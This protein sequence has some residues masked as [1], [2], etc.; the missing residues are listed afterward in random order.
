M[1]ED[2]TYTVDFS[3]LVGSKP[4]RVVS[5][6]PSVTESLFD[7]QLQERIIAVTDYCEHPAEGVARLPRVGGTKNPNI[8]QIVALN[9]DLV[10]MNAEENRREDAQ[11][12]SEA[13]VR[14]YAATPHT[15]AEAINELWNLVAIFDVT[16]MVPRIQ[17]IDRVFDMVSQAAA[18]GRR[19]RT[20]VPIW[21]APWMT[22]NAETYV[23]DLLFHL[24]A[25]NVFAER[26]RQ[27]PLAAD[28]GDAE[29]LAADDPR[30]ADRDTRY[31]RVSLD[32]IIAAA[33]ELILL[34]TEPYAFT[35]DDARALYE[36]EDIPAAAHGNIYLVDGSLLTW[37]GTRLAHT[38]KELPPLIDDVRARLGLNNAEGDSDAP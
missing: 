9:P 27:F 26:E 11:K 7:L 8:E 22:F 4:R 32:E 12:L 17:Q 33:P 6:V 23:H 14:V 19:V 3:D 35:E 31:P 38:L 25:E 28:T 36:L 15:V 37:H 1:S 21:K 5:L 16:T 10:I 13:G 18:S 20:F 34:P 24:G 2:H 29:P 30:I